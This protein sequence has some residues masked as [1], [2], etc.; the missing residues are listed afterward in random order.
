[1]NGGRL[2]NSSAF[3]WHSLVDHLARVCV[4]VCWIDQKIVLLSN[5]LWHGAKKQSRLMVHLTF[6]G[7]FTPFLN[8]ALCQS[9]EYQTKISKDEV[10]YCKRM[11]SPPPRL[12]SLLLTSVFFLLLVFIEQVLYAD[13]LPRR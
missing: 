4:C 2:L 1:M 9:A 12:Y 10:L 6:L 3:E 5:E 7:I 8:I 13:L 11:N